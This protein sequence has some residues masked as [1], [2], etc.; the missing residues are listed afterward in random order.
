MFLLFRTRLNHFQND[1]NTKLITV[2]T[3]S[4]LLKF[5][6]NPVIYNRFVVSFNFKSMISLFD[7]QIV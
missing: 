6:V 7:K 1:H 5:Q 3:R 4:I 2:A